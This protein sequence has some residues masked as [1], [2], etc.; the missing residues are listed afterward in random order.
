MS[1]L[2]YYAP[3]RRG[4]IV[5][6]VGFCVLMLDDQSFLFGLFWLNDLSSS[7]RAAKGTDPMRKSRL[8]ALRAQWAVRGGKRE[9]WC[10]FT[11]G[12]FGASFG[13]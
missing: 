9:V 3:L 7:V 11:F 4:S 10:A 1:K 2:G 5:L 13:G 6:R 8:F 12:L